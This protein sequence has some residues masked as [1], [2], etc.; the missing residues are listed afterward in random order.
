M[1]NIDLNPHFILIA[2]WAKD[3][4]FI[5]AG[6]PTHTLDGKQGKLDS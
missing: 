2:S 5:P 6:E 3:N 4:E 1:H